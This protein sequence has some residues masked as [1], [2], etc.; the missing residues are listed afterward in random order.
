MTTYPQLIDLT[1]TIVHHMQAY[2]GELPPQLLPISDFKKDGFANYLLQI[3]MHNGTHIDGPMH[4]SESSIYL[5]QLPTERFVGNGILCN[6]IAHSTREIIKQ[7]EQKDLTNSIV[8][9]YTGHSQNFGKPGYFENYPAVDM[10][11][12]E[13]LSSKSVSIIGV[14]SPS[15]DHAP[16]P[17]H[18][19]L[20]AKNILILENLTN[21]EKLIGVTEFKAMALPLKT[22]TDS[23][24]VRVMA[25]ILH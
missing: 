5:S 9:I 18:H 3:G 7:L 15:P 8:L 1:Q 21:L 16:Y 25:Q 13:F 19:L 2:P 22:Q 11:L 10:Q 6:T 20:F 24:P 14:D 17:A 12:L 4:M 23:A